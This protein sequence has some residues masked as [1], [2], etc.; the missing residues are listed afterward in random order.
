MA[1]NKFFEAIAKGEKNTPPE[2]SLKNNL[3]MA[4]D[5]TPSKPHADTSVKKNKVSP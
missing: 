1:K 4:V 3:Q 2:P 5:R